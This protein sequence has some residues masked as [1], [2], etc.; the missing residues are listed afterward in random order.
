MGKQ[1]TWTIRLGKFEEN[2][3]I[4]RISTSHKYTAHFRTIG[5]CNRQRYEKGWIYV[6]ESRSGRIVGFACIRDKKRIPE[7]ELDIIC[8]LP[9]FRSAGV[10][11]RLIKVLAGERPPHIERVVLNVMKDN[12]EAVRFYERLGFTHA[13]D[14]MERAAHRMSFDLH[15][16]VGL[17]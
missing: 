15:R 16:Y 11:E 3:E 12:P 6:A 10:G 4:A 17:I 8:V 2:K 5:Y 9:E 14:A 7:C 1:R 13:G